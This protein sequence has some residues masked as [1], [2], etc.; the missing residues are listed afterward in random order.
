MQYVVVVVVA[1]AMF[2]IKE[3]WELITKFSID[4]AATIAAVMW[5][6]GTKTFILL[7]RVL[8]II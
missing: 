4:Y 2:N 5:L 6:Q 1:F 7:M 8:A 3:I